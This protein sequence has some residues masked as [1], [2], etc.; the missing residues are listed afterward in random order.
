MDFQC[1]N[2]RKVPWEVLKTSASASVFNSSLRT[3]RMLMHENPC[4]IPIF[5]HATYMKML[6]IHNYF[7][8]KKKKKKKKN[9]AQLFFCFFFCFFFLHLSLFRMQYVYVFMSY[10]KPVYIE[11]D[12]YKVIVNSYDNIPTQFKYNVSTSVLCSAI[13]RTWPAR[14]DRLLLLMFVGRGIVRIRFH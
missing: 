3:W 5:M 2:I 6:E 10:M 9:W 12:I 7:V 11:V 8:K 4:L 14:G 13:H 1:I